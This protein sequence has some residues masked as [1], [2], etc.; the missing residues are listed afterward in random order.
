MTPSSVP[1]TPIAADTRTGAHLA[2]VSLRRS[3]KYERP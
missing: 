1:A 2:R 3:L